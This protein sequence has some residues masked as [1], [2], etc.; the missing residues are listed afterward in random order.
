MSVDVD[1][2]AE[3]FLGLEVDAVEELP[4]DREEHEGNSCHGGPG[5]VY[6][7][8]RC[9]ECGSSDD[10][11]DGGL[12]LICEKFYKHITLLNTTAT[13]KGCGKTIRIRDLVEYKGRRN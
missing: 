1:T 6:V 12:Q 3:L 5:E 10:V 13:H 7:V 2:E 4:C 9:P 8:F 11:P